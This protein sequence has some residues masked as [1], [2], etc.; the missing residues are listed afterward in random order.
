MYNFSRI[1]SAR[2]GDPLMVREFAATLVIG[3]G[4]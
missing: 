1:V 4:K 3:T 2:Q